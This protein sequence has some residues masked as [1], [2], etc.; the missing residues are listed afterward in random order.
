MKPTYGRVSRYGLVAFASSLDQIGP[1]TK[2]VRDAAGLLGIMAGLDPHDSTSL[3][4]P[5]PDYL[6]ELTGDI[7]GLKIGI[8][9]ICNQWMFPKSN[10]RDEGC[11]VFEGGELNAV[12]YRC[13]KRICDST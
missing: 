3:D 9:G 13:R 2:D 8:P 11:P 6:G 4:H 5:V 1:M 7:R 12:K 10:R